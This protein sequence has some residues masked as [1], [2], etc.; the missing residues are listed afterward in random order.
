MT[1]PVDRT[2]SM[3]EYEHKRDLPVRLADNHHRP[4]PSAAATGEVGGADSPTAG[5]CAA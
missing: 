2:V 3:D 4:L 5:S 1:K